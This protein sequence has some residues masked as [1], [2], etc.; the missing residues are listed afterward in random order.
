[1]NKREIS[2]PRN[3]GSIDVQQI[4]SIGA[5]LHGLE[6]YIN[7]DVSAALRFRQR[8]SEMVGEGFSPSFISFSEDVVEDKGD[9]LGV[10]LIQPVTIGIEYMQIERDLF[11]TRRSL[12]I[13]IDPVST[14]LSFEDLRLVEIVLKRL[15]SDK[16]KTGSDSASNQQY[17]LSPPNVMNESVE[18]SRVH[19]QV[20]FN[21]TRL[22]LG[23]RTDGSHVVVN[24]IQNPAY[25]SQIDHGDILISV[26]HESVSNMSLDQIVRILA[27]SQRPVTVG[28][29]R[30][31]NSPG[32]IESVET[33]TTN[34]DS[35]GY[36]DE[37]SLSGYPISS[38]S[39]HFRSW[40]QLG[41]VFEKSVC[42][43][44]PVVSKL[45]SSID[46]AVV[47]SRSVDEFDSEQ[48]EVIDSVFKS[49]DTR[50]PRIG[51]VVVAV[52]EIPVEE[53]GAEEVWQVLSKMQDC[54]VSQGYIGS[55]SSNDVT[56]SLTFQEMHSS[57]WGKIDTMDVSSA[58]MALSFIDDLNGRDMPL[59]RG[60]LSSVKIHIERGLGIN[61]HILDNTIPSL[62]T[63][64]YSDSGEEGSD[65]ILSSDQVADIQTECIVSF[66]AISICSMDYFRP[67][68]SFWEPLLEP[69]QLYFH[70]EKQNGSVEANRP[71]QVALEVSDRLLHDQF[72]RSGFAQNNHLGEPHMVS[73]NV[74]DA[75]AEVIVETL[76]RWKDWRNNIVRESEEVSIEYTNDLVLEE[77]HVPPGSPIPN[78]YTG[79]ENASFQG[80]V[81][82][83]NQLHFAQRAAAKKA[84]QGALIFA[85]KR[86]AE[87]SKK[88]DS[89]KP[90]IFRNRTG[91]S[92]AFV[93]QGRGLRSRGYSGRNRRESGE[94]SSFTATIGEYDGLEEYGHESIT[95]LADQ[96]DAKF[97]MDL[98]DENFEDINRRRSTRLFANKIRSY[99][100][101]YPDL[102]VAIQAVAGIL[103]EPITNLQVLKVGSSIRH[104]TVKEDNSSYAGLD[105]TRNS[106]QVVWSV[107]IEDNRRI[108]TLSTAV[109]V[110]SAGISMPIEVGFRHDRNDD[111]AGRTS[112][113]SVNSIGIARSD[114]PFYMPLW[115][116]LKL[117]PV[118]IYVR[119]A[120][121]G[122]FEQSWS[123]SSVLHFG[124]RVE[125]PMIANGRRLSAS[126]SGRWTW[127]ETFPGLRY[128]CCHSL[129]D[130]KYPTWFSV[131][132]SSSSNHSEVLL[133][134]QSVDKLKDEVLR[135]RNEF[136]AYE[137][138]SITLDSGLT[139][140]NLL[141]S[142]IE[143]E[144]I[145]GDE[146]A[147][148]SEPHSKKQG[149]HFSFD[150]VEPD[151]SKFDTL[152]SGECT[153]VFEVNY[154]A[155]VPKLR[156]K[157]QNL[158]S[159]SSWASLNL[160]EAAEFD[161][162]NYGSH[163]DET[164]TTGSISPSQVN[165][166]I[167]DGD[168][169]IPMTFGVRIEPKMT[170]DESHRGRNYGVEVIIYAE[171]WI[172]NITSLPLNFGCPAYQ[173]YEPE[174]SLTTTTPLN[175]SI[176]K[177]TAES[178][179][180][181][182]TS[183]LEVGDKGAAF[184]QKVAKED[185][186]RSGLIESLPGQ[187]CRELIE[188]VF[189]Y[190]EIESSMVKR[191]WWASESYNGYHKQIYDVDDAG[192]NW[193]WF[194]EKWVS[195]EKNSIYVFRIEYF[196]SCLIHRFGR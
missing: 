39:L 15:S 138:L 161:D 135:Q 192:A 110:V 43:Q 189:E 84:A 9:T 188:E 92:I 157:H 54:N 166:Q 152:K 153:E 123:D 148:Q 111:N 44:F 82:N 96:E 38:Y 85:Q 18:K 125:E 141:P 178:A 26:G 50:L 140:R 19:F 119:P 25:D 181:E 2:G 147:S 49:D 7:P 90:F 67:R 11:P 23:L 168:F 56:F 20:V 114:C 45:L 36:R 64:L 196:S 59:F 145:Q 97:S 187:Q 193:K 1:M 165:V 106:I 89:A 74:T 160:N 173:I 68:V 155:T 130:E 14:M 30:I 16:G 65:A 121:G 169:G 156:I 6:T 83:Q 69:S 158:K 171:L 3:S 172:R 105:S 117:E 8:H 113:N 28:F 116:A 51:A 37:D 150:E 136:E 47:L 118:S 75:A 13:N 185:T 57:A 29:E 71:A 195:F 126:L 52:D 41:L 4:T 183:L 127:E 100:G 88:S 132:G 32:S 180:M 103:V 176:A 95:E 154:T 146:P 191:K 190:V 129:V 99:E 5:Q 104:L 143:M 162:D 98:I 60:K 77:G 10:A 159:W 62:L 149:T 79:A 93:Q 76:T 91:I 78:I 87:T 108:L 120:S 12:Q 58:G 151:V 73:I 35:E 164:T 109:R 115:L 70:L 184:N 163:A 55:D 139:V 175:E 133:S 80:E 94:R 72:A 128:L 112:E 33:S 40:M 102:M 107:E 124:L 182:L 194:D 101:R 174:Q 179:L 134:T 137:V 24:N 46:E 122:T 81:T 86:G 144:V 53:L 66:S 63:P 142:M 34:E 61:A 42:G 22:G 21:S 131:F 170:N 167:P 31:I 177:F 27:R 48:I 17:I 186:E